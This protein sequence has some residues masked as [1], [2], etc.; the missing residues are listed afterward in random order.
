MQGPQGN[1]AEAKIEGKHRGNDHKVRKQHGNQR[2]E[3]FN[4][5]SE[6]VEEDDPSGHDHDADERPGDGWLD[7]TDLLRRHQWKGVRMCAQPYRCIGRGG[8]WMIRVANQH[9]ALSMA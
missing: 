8:E 7:V 4:V 6:V 2:V 5:H 3:P 1:T 9:R